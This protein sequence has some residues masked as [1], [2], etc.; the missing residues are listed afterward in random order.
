MQSSFTDCTG[1][2]PLSKRHPKKTT[3]LPL[4]PSKNPHLA[5]QRN[6]CFLM[7]QVG[8]RE[9]L[10]ALGISECKTRIEI[11]LAQQEQAAQALGEFY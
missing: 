8:F 10:L 3:V 9:R 11:C 4:P 1:I 5:L 7:C 2:P 6:V